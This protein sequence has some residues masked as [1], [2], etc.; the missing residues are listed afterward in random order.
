MDGEG[1][2]TGQ[3]HLIAVF[4]GIVL[5]GDDQTPALASSTEDHANVDELLFIR[6]GPVDLV[7]VPCTQ[8]DHDVLVAEEE[9]DSAG[10]V[11]LVH[12]VEV[13]HFRDV[14]EIYDSK[15]L[16]GFTRRRQHLVHLHARVVPVV[17]KPHDNEAL[18]LGEDR[19]VD[20]PAGVKMWEEIRHTLLSALTSSACGLNG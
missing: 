5:G 2:K 11:Q 1:G 13:W 18:L 7:V 10:V 9:H 15:V 3:Q 17:T 19:L 14:Y 6:H 4:R 16:H 20:G 8:I 12:R